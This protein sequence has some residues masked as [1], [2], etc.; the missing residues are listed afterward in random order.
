MVCVCVYLYGLD[1]V[2]HGVCRGRG[3]GMYCYESHWCGEAVNTNTD[4]VPILHASCTST[5]VCVC[6]FAHS[7]SETVV[8][9]ICGYGYVCVCAHMCVYFCKFPYVCVS[10]F[11]SGDRKSTR[12]NS[13]HT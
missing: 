13:S 10:R 7:M 3:Y 12:L 1:G 9:S 2:C 6:V 11:L 8:V 5:P 4:A